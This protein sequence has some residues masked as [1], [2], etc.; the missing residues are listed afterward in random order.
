MWL[1][2][3]KSNYCRGELRLAKGDRARILRSLEILSRQTP[4]CCKITALEKGKS[5]FENA[6]IFHVFCI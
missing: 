4:S 3:R 2:E 5:T 1:L 6:S